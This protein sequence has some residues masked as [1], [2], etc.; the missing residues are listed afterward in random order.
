MN[1]R[2]E[3]NTG[4]EIDIDPETVTQVEDHGER[5]LCVVLIGTIPVRVKGV[6]AKVAKEIEKLRGTP[7]PV[8]P[9][10]P[11]MR[12]TTPDAIPAALAEFREGAVTGQSENPPPPSEEPGTRGPDSNPP[13]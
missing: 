7:C 12:M 9:F 1:H 13:T 10:K 3:N 4:T 6:A 2:I 11:V 8:V 5:G